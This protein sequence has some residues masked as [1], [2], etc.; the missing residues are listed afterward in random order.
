MSTLQKTMIREMPFNM[1]PDSGPNHMRWKSEFRADLKAECE[2]ED[3]V[4]V[5][6]GSKYNLT[7]IKENAGQ[8]KSRQY[9]L[10]LEYV[11]RQAPKELPPT[12][13]LLPTLD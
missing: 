3:M 8:K 11:L 9:Q 13:A 5:P 4:L 6:V 7:R 2:V 1:H 10:H 12:K